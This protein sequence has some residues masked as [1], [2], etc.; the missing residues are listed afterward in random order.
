MDVTLGVK[1]DPIEYRYSFDWLFDLLCECGIQFVQLG[2]F[3]ELYLADDPFFEDLRVKAETR[4]LRIK[5]CFTSH[6]ELGGFFTGNTHLVKVARR[7]YERYIDV[8]SLVGA[9]FVGSNPG[10]VYRD[11]PFEKESGIACYLLHMWEL[12]HYAFGKGLRGLTIEPMSC[13]FEP[14]SL[15]REITS[16]LGELDQYHTQ[17]PESTVPV[18]LCG[19]ISHGVVNANRQVVHDNYDLFEL[20]IPFMAEFHI[21]NTDP[22]FD[23]TFG[24]SPDERRRGIVDL[25]RLRSMVYANEPRWPIQDITGYLEIGGPKTGRDYSDQK[26]GAALRDSLL[27]VKDA[28]EVET[29]AGVLNA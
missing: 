4:G 6:R 10:A 18:Y 27:A 1:T 11:R 21:K 22:V 25:Q 19:D 7:A 2:S 29:M 15:P 3:F 13:E 23:S 26:L 16:M 14:P 8:A 17:H 28:F 24:F 5:S 20:E 12:M 9:D